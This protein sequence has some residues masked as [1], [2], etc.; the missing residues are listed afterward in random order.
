MTDS[1]KERLF[2]SLD[3]LCLLLRSIDEKFNMALGIQPMEEKSEDDAESIIKAMNA[4]K[5]H[6]DCC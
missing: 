4:E 6:C 1:E 2:N 5:E 3:E